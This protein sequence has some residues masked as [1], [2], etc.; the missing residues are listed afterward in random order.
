MNTERS[1]TITL[2][3]TGTI[4]EP[5]KAVIEVWLARKEASSLNIDLEP[6]GTY[7]ALSIV[8][9]VYYPK[10]RKNDPSECGQ[11]TETIRE[12][13]GSDS[14]VAELCDLWN[15]WHLNGLRAGTRVQGE[16]LR[17][18]PPQ[19]PFFPESHYEKSCK[20][21]ETAGLYEDRGYKYGHRW[22]VEDLP[23]DVLKRLGEL[24]RELGAHE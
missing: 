19:P 20:I 22:L 7:T 2:N 14:K 13:W 17:E 4:H 12:F 10:D 21:L 1:A 24:C 23:K 8:A 11:C 6:C 15:R 18:N 9:D 16:H 3:R 5:A